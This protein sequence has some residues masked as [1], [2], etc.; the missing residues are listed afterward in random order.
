MTISKTFDI[1]EII[2][3]LLIVSVFISSGTEKTI[4]LRPVSI[5]SR[6]LFSMLYKVKHKLKIEKWMTSEDILEANPMIFDR[7]ESAQD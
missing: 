4:S 2:N 1:I 3:L 6:I 5:E 7:M